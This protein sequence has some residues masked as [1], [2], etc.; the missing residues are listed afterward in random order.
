[1]DEF[2]HFDSKR[3]R[4]KA[5]AMNNH[6]LREKIFKQRR[7]T[8]AY[9]TSAAVSAAHAPVTGGLSLIVT[10][11]T[12]RRLHITRQ[13]IKILDAEWLGRPGYE[14]RTLPR[15][16]IRDIL[17]PAAIG[18]AVAEGADVLGET[19]AAAGSAAVADAGYDGADYLG[20]QLSHGVALDPGTSAAAA[21]G[22][23]EG[24]RESAQV[25]T[26]QAVT[27]GTYVPIG[28]DQAAAYYMGA[29]AGIYAAQEVPPFLAGVAATAATERA[30]RSRP[31]SC[32]IAPSLSPCSYC[33][34]HCSGQ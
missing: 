4:A 1:M 28:A 27:G 13:K 12:A 3:Y 33:H 5:S 19:L 26:G 11:Y 22:M 15:N 31:V 10:A 7:R 8:S 25:I 2:I 32:W 14:H 24:I 9:V 6:A 29:G 21:H 16:R 23:E 17:I 20:D 30:L 18:V 34:P